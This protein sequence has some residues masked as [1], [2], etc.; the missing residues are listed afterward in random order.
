MASVLRKDVVDRI[1]V[2]MDTLDR[3]NLKLLRITLCGDVL[4]NRE[5]ER[6]RNDQCEESGR[7]RERSA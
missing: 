5:T 3:E 6:L 7:D 1:R 4:L 2:G